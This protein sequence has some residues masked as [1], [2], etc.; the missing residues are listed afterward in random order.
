MI[1]I[2]AMHTRFVLCSYTCKCTDTA[3]DKGMKPCCYESTSKLAFPV[4]GV[5]ANVNGTLVIFELDLD[6]SGAPGP[7]AK[8]SNHLES[9]T[10]NCT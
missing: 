1:C 4:S 5:D 6:K 8:G 9:P 3:R 7:Q 2:D 10:G